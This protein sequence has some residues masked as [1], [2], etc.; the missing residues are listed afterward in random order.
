M[1]NSDTHHAGQGGLVKPADVGRI[2]AVK[3]GMAS[4]VLAV[5]LCGGA[6]GLRAAEFPP[7]FSNVWKTNGLSADVPVWPHSVV[8]LSNSSQSMSYDRI[9]F[10]VLFVIFVGWFVVWGILATGGKVHVPGKHSHTG[11][12]DLPGTGGT[13]RGRWRGPL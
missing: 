9:V 3:F 6:L 5:M 12:H 1:S 10:A 13:G 2:A 4:A 8:P 7:E 11:S